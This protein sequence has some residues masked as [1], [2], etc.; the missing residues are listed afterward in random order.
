M[1]CVGDEQPAPAF[2]SKHLSGKR[3]HR[4]RNHVRFATR[5]EGFAIQVAGVGMMVDHLPD[6]LVEEIVNPLARMGTEHLSARVDQ[7]ERRPS[8]HRVLLPY[9]HAAVV[10]DGMFDPVAH[11]SL[12]DP[13]VVL[14][15]IELGR[16]DTD[17]HQF[18]SVLPFKALEVFKSVDTV[19]AAVRPEIE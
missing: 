14:F 16:M 4:V 8:P 18:I 13:L 6:H 3:K 15:R 10:H 7:D 12:P 17:H 1:V 5:R 9:A 19:D 2:V 11:D